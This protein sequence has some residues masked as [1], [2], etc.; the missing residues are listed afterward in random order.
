MKDR[1]GSLRRCQDDFHVTAGEARE[2][3]ACIDRL[4]LAA[5]S[6]RVLLDRFRRFRL[7][8]ESTRPAEL[9]LDPWTDIAWSCRP[10]TGAGMAIWIRHECKSSNTTRLK[11]RVIQINHSHYVQEFVGD[12]I[13]STY[14]LAGTSTIGRGSDKVSKRYARSACRPPRR[15]RRGARMGLNS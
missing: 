15:L 4:R 5:S 13:D 2:I 12:H 3:D 8:S 11:G 10:R 1:F 6:E 7:E 14:I 9:N